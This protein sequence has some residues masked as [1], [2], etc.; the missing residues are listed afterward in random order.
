MVDEQTGNYVQYDCHGAHVP[1]ALGEHRGL[2]WESGLVGLEL[3]GRVGTKEAQE[4]FVNC[5][6]ASR[7]VFC[8][9]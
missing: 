5:L 7:I 4:L 6:V 3:S 1:R 9:L 2:L 8:F